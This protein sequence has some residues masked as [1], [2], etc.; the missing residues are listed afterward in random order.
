MMSFFNSKSMRHRVVKEW[1]HVRANASKECGPANEAV[2]DSRWRTTN[3]HRF[4]GYAL[5]CD[6]AI[7]IHPA[8]TASA[9][10]RSTL[11]GA[12]SAR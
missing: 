3:S 4:S 10:Q 2:M 9:P 6:R 11:R 12:A 1:T 5:H 7:A 8:I